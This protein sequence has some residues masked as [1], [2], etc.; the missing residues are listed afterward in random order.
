M[1]DLILESAVLCG[2]MDTCENEICRIILACSK[3]EQFR[4]APAADGG[5]VQE[6]CATVPIDDVISAVRRNME[7][8]YPFE[9][10]SSVPSKL[11]V[12]RLYPEILDGSENRSASLMSGGSALLPDRSFSSDNAGSDGLSGPAD[13][14]MEYPRFMTGTSGFSAAERGTS[15]HIF[16]QFADFDNLC[17]HGVGAEIARLTDKGFIEQFAASYLMDRIRS[18][19]EIFRE[20][21]FNVRLPAEIFTSDEVLSEKL[22][23][24]GVK[25]TVQGV[26]DCV[27]TDMEDN[28]MLIDYKT[29]FM[30][31]Y[32]IR[33]PKAGE[34]KLIERH[35]RQ[36]SYYAMACSLIFGRFPDQSAI[37][38]LTLG[39]TVDLTEEIKKYLA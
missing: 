32:E 23:M 17:T 35:I 34:A 7:F 24:S 5:A 30:S 39:R 15:T 28:L 19:K 38:S 31:P 13:G 36:L 18:A 12:S 21:R 8:S 16:M 33:N 4:S 6:N 29:D 26:F 9:Y 37:Y 14:M 27:F 11:S 1:I 20:F 10:L 25:I 3:K 2:L 22:K